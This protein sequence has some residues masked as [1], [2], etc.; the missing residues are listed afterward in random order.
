MQYTDISNDT[1]Q[2]RWTLRRVHLPCEAL[3]VNLFAK[4]CAYQH[5]KKIY[6]KIYRTIFLFYS[7]S[8]MFFYLGSSMFLL[9]FFCIIRSPIKQYSNSAPPFYGATA[10]R[11]MQ[12]YTI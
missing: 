12:S 9:L 6:K 5:Q 4:G 1:N 10:V 11:G 8:S 7:G 2:R 3:P